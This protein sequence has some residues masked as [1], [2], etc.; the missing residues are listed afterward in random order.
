MINPRQQISMAADSY[1]SR[2]PIVGSLLLLLTLL[3][4]LPGAATAQQSERPLAEVNNGGSSLMLTPNTPAD[5]WVL[6]VTGPDGYNWRQVFQ[7]QPPSFSTADLPEGNYSYSLQAVRREANGPNTQSGSF[8]VAGG[9]ITSVEKPAPIGS[10]GDDPQL[11]VGR[12]AD[13]LPLEPVEAAEDDVAARTCTPGTPG[14][15]TGEVGSDIDGVNAGVSQ[16][17]NGTTPPNGFDSGPIFST[18]DQV[19]LDDLIVDGSICVG[20]D[21][22]NG[23]SFGFDTIRVKENNLRIK[24]VD[25]SSSNSFPS[26]DWQ[27]TA[28]DSSNGGGN[29]FAIDDIT[30]AKQPFRVNAGAPTN[31]LLIR[32]N[33]NVGFGSSNPLVE[34]HAVD[35]DTPTLRLEQNG[36]TGFTPQTWDLAGNE[37]NFFIRDVSNGSK[38]PF[39]IRPGAPTSSIDIASDGDVGMGTASP[40]AA[41]HVRRSNETAKIMVEEVDSTVATRTVLHLI[42]NGNPVIKMEDSDSG[43]TW[44]YQARNDRFLVS[45]AGSGD[46]EMELYTDGRFIIGTNGGG[47]PVDNLFLGSTGNLTIQ[48]NLTELSTRVAKENLALASGGEVLNTLSKLPIYE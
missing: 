18:L 44:D 48:G 27:L 13:L 8:A 1:S 32:T 2:L 14:C 38:L 16:A 10:T 12:P 25:T 3:A 39:R 17:G 4:L 33:G 29:Y 43:T 40:S 31:S 41:L 46:L 28:N 24:F 6:T 36:S 23:E 5:S 9:A 45:K 34:L 30:G 20:F 42:N 15:E 11:N 22:V 35:G 19:I 26:N 7:G 37:T 21:C 47:S